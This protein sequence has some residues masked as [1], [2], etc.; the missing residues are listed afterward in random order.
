[1]HDEQE[2]VSTPNKKLKVQEF[3]TWDNHFAKDKHRLQHMKRA[4]EQPDSP[5]FPQCK[6][7]RISALNSK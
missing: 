3:F 6:T 2:T 7:I 4:K 1:M 5:M